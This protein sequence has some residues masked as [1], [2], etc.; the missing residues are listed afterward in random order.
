LIVARTFAHLDLRL[1]GGDAGAASLVV[2]TDQRLVGDHFLAAL[3]HDFADQAD[4][5]RRDLDLAR[6]RL[7]Q[8]RRHRLPIL[9]VRGRLLRGAGFGECQADDRGENADG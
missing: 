9:V 2:Q 8:P 5:R 4:H 7:D 1:R 3:H 6:A